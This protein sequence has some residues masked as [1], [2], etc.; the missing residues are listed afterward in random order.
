MTRQFFHL[1]VS[2]EV[3]PDEEPYEKAEV[4]RQI[5]RSGWKVEEIHDAPVEEPTPA[6]S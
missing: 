6:P 5:E 2:A 3:I 4:I 1:I